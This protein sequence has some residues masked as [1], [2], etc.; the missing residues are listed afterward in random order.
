[1]TTE[2]TEQCL[3]LRAAALRQAL[4]TAGEDVDPAQTYGCV[5][6]FRYD[7]AQAP[8][9]DTAGPGKDPGS[10]GVPSTH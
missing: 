4:E 3:A 7:V 8:Q 6:W 9:M 2:P 10:G 1:M 5:D